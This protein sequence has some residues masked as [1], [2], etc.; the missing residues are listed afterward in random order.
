[1]NAAELENI[2][3]ALLQQK[4][5][6]LNRSAEFKQE[7][8]KSQLI[9]E[10]VEAASADL[11]NNTQI[12]LHERQLQSLLLIEKALSKFEEGTYGQCECCGGSIH[13]RRLAARPFTS[14]CIECMEEMENS[15]TIIQ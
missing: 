12:I 7:Q 6:I 4:S 8:S 1:M 2:K 9:S 13:L 15:Q 10:E 14:Y 3:H 11:L 5:L